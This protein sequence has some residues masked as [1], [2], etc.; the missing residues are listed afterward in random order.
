MTHQRLISANDFAKALG[1]SR[2]HFFRT[3]RPCV[4]LVRVEG[5]T[6]ARYDAADVDRIIEAGRV[7][8][9]AQAKAKGKK[10]EPAAPSRETVKPRRKNPAEMLREARAAAGLPEI[11]N[12]AEWGFED[13][14]PTKEAKG[15]RK[16]A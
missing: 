9:K 11:I 8:A 16:T 14:A 3:I 12:F 4:Q 6:H 10:A 5:M 2:R 15:R 13:P 7:V 1:I